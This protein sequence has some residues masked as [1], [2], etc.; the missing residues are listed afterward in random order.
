MKKEISIV[1]ISILVYSVAGFAYM[2]K[3]YID[4]DHF[5]VILNALDRIETKL[6]AHIAKD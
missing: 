2:Q 6:D 5:D 1:I 3:T 4:R